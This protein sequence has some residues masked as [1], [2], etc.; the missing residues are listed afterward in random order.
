MPRDV[1]FNPCNIG[2]ESA[3]VN[4]PV[5]EQGLP[6][7][8]WDTS[9]TLMPTRHFR[10][11]CFDLLEGTSSTPWNSTG[12]EDDLLLEF[13]T[14]ADGLNAA[15]LPPVVGGD[16]EFA[17][18]LSDPLQIAPPVATIHGRETEGDSLQ[19][20]STASSFC[21]AV[22]IPEMVP[23][24]NPEQ[25]AQGCTGKKRTRKPNTA[26]EWMTMEFL[27]AGGFLDMPLAVEC[28]GFPPI[29]P[30]LEEAAR[31][32]HMSVAVLK[33]TVRKLGVTRW[34]SRKRNS[35][36]RLMETAQTMGKPINKFGGDITELRRLLEAERKSYQ[37]DSENWPMIQKVRDTYYKT[38]FLHKRGRKEPKAPSTPPPAAPFL[39]SASSCSMPMAKQPPEGLTL[40][41]LQPGRG[42]R[43]GSAPPDVAWG[44]HGSRVHRRRSRRAASIF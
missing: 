34:P 5:E 26:G 36:R 12:F 1:R 17:C 14:G 10:D 33:P 18:D 4:F 28:P 3:A 21:N 30:R 37:G 41:T 15:L 27:E 40:D 35:L 38:R 32:L 29:Q 9:D 16:S 42:A 8:P 39:A 13:S 6:G 2:C 43:S 44:A 24:K 11:C 19:H 25:A 20:P 22:P 7:I 23:Q 31:K